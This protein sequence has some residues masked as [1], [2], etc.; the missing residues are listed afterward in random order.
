MIAL[1]D[2]YTL[3]KNKTQEITLR[4][5]RC[6]KSKFCVTKP[7]DPDDAILLLTLCP[8]CTVKGEIITVKYYNASGEIVKSF[9]G[10]GW[11]VWNV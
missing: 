7:E 3:G 5:M 10:I 2:I 6:N 9:E 4:C 1:N 11:N 8:D